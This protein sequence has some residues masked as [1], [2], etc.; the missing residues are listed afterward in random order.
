MIKASPR[1][2]IDLLETARLEQLIERNQQQRP[3]QIFTEEEW[4]YC[5]SK[6]F[7]LPS[8]AAR[9]AAKEAVMKLFPAETNSKELA[10]NDIEILVDNY[11]APYVNIETDK[12]MEMLMKRY[13]YQTILIS[14]THTKAMACATAV[15]Q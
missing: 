4:Q 10:F 12:K 7:P 9:F 11:G 6:R 15:A 5:Q 3:E 14:L 8:L 2:G 1:I 13:G